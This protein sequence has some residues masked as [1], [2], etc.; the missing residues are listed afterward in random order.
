[1]QDKGTMP[2]DRDDDQGFCKK[3]KKSQERV[4]KC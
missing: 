4:E 1:M 3:E 2:T